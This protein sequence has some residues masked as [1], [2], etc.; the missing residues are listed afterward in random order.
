MAKARE[1]APHLARKALALAFLLT[2]LIF[3]GGWLYH[4]IE[5][6]VAPIDSIYNVVMI[7]T[8]IGSS[9]DPETHTGK[10]FNMVLALVSVGIL[11]SVLGQLFHYF[12][13]RSLHDVL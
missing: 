11:V 10:I 3:G 4:L 9:H 1:R 12:S 8:G 5:P 7:M 2:V 13:T 6:S